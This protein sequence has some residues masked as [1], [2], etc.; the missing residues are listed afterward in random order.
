MTVLA[1]LTELFRSKNVLKNPLEGVRGMRKIIWD[2]N[3]SRIL[4]R[5]S[6]ENITEALGKIFLG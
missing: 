1:C 3:I 4:L 5:D 2:C 6:L